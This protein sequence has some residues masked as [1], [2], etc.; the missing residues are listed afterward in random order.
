MD[1]FSKRMINPAL[2]FLCEYHGLIFALS[3]AIFVYESLF[4][5]FVFY[6][7]VFFREEFNGRA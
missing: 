6:S 2:C 4:F 5:S 1:Q 3:F 7:V